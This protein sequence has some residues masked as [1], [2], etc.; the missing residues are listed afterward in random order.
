MNAFVRQL[1]DW[2]LEACPEENRLWLHQSLRRIESLDE[3]ELALLFSGAGRRLGHELVGEHLEA[4][5]T[6]YWTAADLGRV[7]ALVSSLSASPVSRHRAVTEDLYFR[8]AAS[9]K[10]AVL[11][12]LPLLSEAQLHLELAVE[13]C[14]TNTVS[15][16]SVIACENQ[17]PVRHFDERAFNQLV[18]KTIFLDLDVHRVVGVTG[19]LTP[20][21]QQNLLDFRAERQ[22]AGRAVPP[23]LD[24][25]LE[26]ANR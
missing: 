3:R 2:A 8:G 26:K 17:F 7:A 15:V 22:A 11:L 24:W 18:L 23:G 13:A 16:F 1:R 20:L 6:S 14:R 12:A 4:C 10:R 9:E 19:R 5:N 25:L 21:L